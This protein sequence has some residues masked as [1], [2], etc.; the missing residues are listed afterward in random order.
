MTLGLLA[1]LFPAGSRAAPGL[2]TVD[3]PVRID[4]FPY[5]I[6]GSTLDAFSDTIDLYDCGPG[7]DESGDEVI[8]AFEL[9][10]PARVT[11]WVEGD[12]GIVDI[13]VH[14]LADLGLDRGVSTGCVARGNAIAEAELPAGPGYVVVDTYAG[15]AQAGDYVL[16]VYAIG[17]GWFEMPVAEGVTWRARRPLDLDGVPQVLNALHVD[18]DAP[19]VE[20]EVVLPAGCAT[21]AQTAAL[22]GST[23]VAAVNSSFFAGCGQPVSFMKQD[24]VLLA[25]N[26]GGVDRGA[27]GLD[28]AGQPLVG[29]TA[30]GADWPRVMDGQGGIPLL[31]EDGVALQG[32]T[33]WAAEGLTSAS[34]LGA[35]PR[36]VLGYDAQGDVVLATV[37]GRRLNAAGM[38]LDA[39][40]T[41]AQAEL[42]GVGV[43]NLD[44]GGSTTMW[45]AG[46]TPNGVV[47]YPSDAGMVELADHGGSRSVVGAVVIHGQPYNW[48]PRFQTE[49]VLEASVGVDYAYD[50]DAIDL[51]VE[52]VVEYALVEGPAGMSIDAQD[53]TVTYLAGVDALPQAQVTVQA[54]DGHGGVGEQSFV[55]TIDGAQ[56]PGDTG[57][58]D[59]GGPGGPSSG[60]ANGDGSSMGSTLGDDTGN[61]TAAQGE[62]TSGCGCRG[63]A[64][65]RGTA[66]WL[67]L[68]PGLA[69]VVRRRR[70]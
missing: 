70:W 13:D 25:T 32:A 4:A 14:I 52:D 30:P 15:D 22:A 2:G 18:L 41:W 34:F 43:V 16:H 63:G 48:S 54:S 44:G 62:P 61:E 68:L 31:V 59:S 33:A 29:R 69:L 57:L 45:I 3:D 35:N 56:G 10:E 37:D 20:L 64:R 7:L 21:V 66:W 6:T 67:W 38:S 49:P 9:L 50:A 42:G 40:A 26:G 55:L 12:D 60:V 1:L 28:A 39:L 27:F 23:A 36:T 19:G 11:A 51:N 17:E 5:A 8:H 47:D 46:I 58:D 53:G 65:G 24:G